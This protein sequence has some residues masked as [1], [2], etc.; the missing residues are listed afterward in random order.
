M[1]HP[2]TC[3]SGFYSNGKIYVFGGMSVKGL[4]TGNDSEVYDIA[5]N[6]WSEFK[7]KLGLKM[8]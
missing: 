6:T 8:H 1:K 2:R 4:L 3:F 5:T 7:L